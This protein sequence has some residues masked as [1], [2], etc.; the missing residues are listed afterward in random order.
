LG[1]PESAV[2]VVYV[3]RLAASKN[4]IGLLEAWQGVVGSIG[5]A[6]FLVLVGG[7]PLQNEVRAHILQTGQKGSVLQAGTQQEVM[8]WLHAA[9]TYVLASLNEG[10]SNSLLEAMS[11]G[12]PI[13]VS[14]VSGCIEAVEQ[15]RAGLLAHID[16][17]GDLEEKLIRMLRSEDLRRTCSLAARS[18]VES[19]YS[20]SAVAGRIAEVYHTVIDGRAVSPSRRQYR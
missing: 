3:G 19:R 11:C 16:T 10:L 20:L 8:P 15:G 1:I 14:R 18:Y 7:G 13:V 6:A 5:S 17:P 12:L 4:I 2:V 9:D